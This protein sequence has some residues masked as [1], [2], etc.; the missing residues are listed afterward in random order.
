MSNLNTN[1]LI[2]SLPQYKIGKLLLAVAL[3]LMASMLFI[4]CKKPTD[5][6]INVIKNTLFTKVRYEQSGI[7]I[8]VVD[9]KGKAINN[10]IITMAGKTYYTSYGATYVKE[11][12][13]N[14]YLN[15][16]TV[17]HPDYFKTYKSFTCVEGTVNY[18]KIVMHKLS[19]RYIFPSSVGASMPLDNNTF[20]N[21]PANALKYKS[22]SKPYNGTAYMHA[23]VI[24]DKTQIT[25]KLPGLPIALLTNGDDNIITGT[26][27]LAVEIKTPTGDELQ[28]DDYSYAEVK[29]PV[30]QFAKQPEPFHYSE[31]N[32][33]W[34]QYNTQIDVKENYYLFKTKEFSW[35][36]YVN[37]FTAYTTIDGTL[38]LGSNNAPLS[39]FTIKSTSGTNAVRHDVQTNSTGFFSLFVR[40]R[41]VTT[42]TAEDICNTNVYNNPVTVATTPI[43]LGDILINLTNTAT[44]T[45]TLRNC[46]NAPLANDRVV[47]VAHSNQMPIRQYITNAQG[48]ITYVVPTCGSDSIDVIA[49]DSLSRQM[50]VSTYVL[51]KGANII[52]HS[53]CNTFGQFFVDSV[54]DQASPSIYQFNE[55]MIE[56]F[57]HITY[58]RE[59]GYFNVTCQNQLY[60][61][62]NNWAVAPYYDIVYPVRSREERCTFKIRDIGSTGVTHLKLYKYS[63][64]DDEAGNAWPFTYKTSSQ[65]LVDSIPVTITSYPSTPGGFI[66]GTFNNNANIGVEVNG[67]TTNKALKMRG[68]FRFKKFW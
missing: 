59:A 54:Y 15:T 9:D 27:L 4:T 51:Q 8:E 14:K 13:L 42:L 48:K 19:S 17:E 68:T 33:R 43:N 40:Q 65:T 52:D 38:K 50:D 39:N 2:Q 46:L 64:Q 5:Q 28:I 56:P 57:W 30:S 32:K 41:D 66:I 35:W 58:T 36:Y 49:Y 18:V 7:S 44:A 16:I 31:L 34:E 26:H 21:I 1:K 55:Y 63:T 47:I 22:N 45:I 25:N 61:P 12:Q 60:K 24:T 3:P 23:A 37:D 53:V 10:A 62:I 29:I 20:V 67:V 11:A 6:P